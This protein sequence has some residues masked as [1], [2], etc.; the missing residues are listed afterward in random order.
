M[1]IPSSY[2]NFTFKRCSTFSHTHFGILY[3]LNKSSVATIGQQHRQWKCHYSKFFKSMM[4]SSSS[5]PMH[6]K[7]LFRGFLNQTWIIEIFSSFF[8]VIIRIN[9]PQLPREFGSKAFQGC[10]WNFFFCSFACFSGVWC[11]FERSKRWTWLNCFCVP[12]KP[13]VELRMTS[14][15]SCQKVDN[16]WNEKSFCSSFP[17]LLLTLL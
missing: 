11:D 15:V 5:F 7:R 4:M 13:K 12:I 2:N 10:M 16:S 6:L 9:L 14:A 3:I 17:A 1:N 8:F